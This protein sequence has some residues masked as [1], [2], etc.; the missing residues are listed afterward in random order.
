MAKLDEYLDRV[1]EFEPVSTA[2]VMAGLSAANLIVG[3][4][5]M[6]KS[7]FT[8][9]ARMCSDLQPREKAMC[10]VRA[11]MLAKN[12]EL[13]ALKSNMAKCAKAKDQQKCKE[14]LS[15]K[16]QKLAQ[17]IKFLADRFEGVKKQQYTK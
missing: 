10:M 12:V 16:M 4:T 11:K 7:H 13:Q 6:Y 2:V 3:A 8:K 17:E 1:Q 15:G 5:R 9:A 14:R